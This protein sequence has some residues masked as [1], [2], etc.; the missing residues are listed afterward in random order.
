MRVAVIAAALMLLLGAGGGSSLPG[1]GF[2]R[3]TTLQLQRLEDRGDVV[4]V[5][6]LYNK[7]IQPG[8]IGNGIL[9][10][11]FVGRGGPLGSGTHLCD[12]VYSLPHG[13]IMA[14][15]LIKSRSFYVL[16]VTGGTGLYSN[17]GGELV[18]STFA[19]CPREERLLFSLETMG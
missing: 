6:L 15:G 11:D 3:V 5:S 7:R 18:A 17:V 14:H 8:A 10:C 13:K 16:A 4:T 19:C 2:V 9:H 12:A 1:P